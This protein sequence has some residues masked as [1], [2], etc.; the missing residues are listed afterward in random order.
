VI[1]IGQGLILL[2]LLITSFGVYA[3]LRLNTFYAR[4]VVT[5]KVEAMGF[6]LIIL[7]AMVLGGFTLTSLKLMMIL[8]FELLT[9][10]IGAHVV[11]RSAWN[12]G[13]RVSIIPGSSESEE[14]ASHG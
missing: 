9:V 1:Y 3:V 11:A 6:M 10:S 13:Y 4:L 8:F 14:E 5:S 7:G 2:G 12:S